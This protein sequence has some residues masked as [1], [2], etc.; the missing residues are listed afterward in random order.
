[1]SATGGDPAAPPKKTAPALGHGARHSRRL[2]AAGR[3]I[4]SQVI[5]DWIVL[6]KRDEP[7][8]SMFYTGYFVTDGEP[9]RRPI[10]FVFNGG[11]GAASAF[12]HMAAVGPR[13]VLFNDDGTMPPPPAR[14]V[15]NLESWLPF[16]DVVCV[17]PVGT[18]F[19]RSHE[20][21]PPPAAGG[22]GAGAVPAAEP[23]KP[24]PSEFWQVKRDLES[25]GEF[26]SRILTAHGRWTSPVVIAGE[27]YGGFRVARLA[28]TLQE[29][30][31]VGLNA[32]ILI[33]PGIQFGTLL[34][35]DYDV[36]HWVEMLPAMAAAA[37][38]NG[39]AGRGSSLTQHLAAAEALAGGA[40][41]NLL[42]Q[43]ERMPEDQRRAV[44]EQAAALIGLP[45]VMLYTALGRVQR[46]QFCRELLRERRLYVGMYDASVTAVDPFPDRPAYAGPDPTLG[47]T[48]RLF[49]AGV[50]AHLRDDLGVKTD[51]DYV[52]LNMEANTA[53]RDDG[54]Q[55]F[56]GGALGSMDELRYGLALNTGMKVLISHG[57][58]DLVT[59]YSSAERLLRL[60]KLTPEQ[61]TRVKTQHF[62]GGHM[63]YTHADSR[64]SFT[65]A[66]RR[67]CF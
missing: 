49:A 48:T 36:D 22:T 6:H 26:I 32:A 3:G 40:W 44:C 20:H 27:S 51:L 57:Y 29:D 24:K 9:A 42:A 12:L 59:P 45:P 1:M 19:S 58:Y 67:F 39:A 43:G 21:A 18:G 5:A 23:A 41:V 14:L 37:H 54:M 2:T 56:I 62:A 38:V 31:G 8:A 28:R 64:A 61:A 7:I 65:D 4:D 53:W 46:E 50:N 30:F 52:L 25:M 33:S 66:V 10:T 13:R 47:G 60:M 34:G 55:H 35:D 63:F 16:T 15:D 11:P 17:D